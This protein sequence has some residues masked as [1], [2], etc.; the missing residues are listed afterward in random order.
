[1]PT[2]HSHQAVSW[3]LPQHAALDTDISVLPRIFEEQINIAILHRALPADVALSANAQSQTSRDWQY[4][5]LGSP[6][7]D[8]KN[9]LR[10]KLPEPS[11]GDALVDDIATAAEAIAFLFDTDTV[12][13]RL[14][15][16]T[17]AMCPRFHCD[18][19]PVRLVTT[20]VGPVANGYLK[21][22]L[23]ARG[24][25]RQHLIAQRLSAT[26]APFSGCMPVI[27]RC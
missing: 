12:G 7:D 22:R 17:A 5:W 25:V 19:L 20:Y 1:M 15:L 23:I 2:P 26:Q 3:R 16:L 4:A 21:M 13:I 27:S 18:N 6:T 14:R 8:F 9:D 24:W 11:A 10:R